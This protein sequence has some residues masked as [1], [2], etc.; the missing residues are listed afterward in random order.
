MT[1]K[2]ENAIVYISMLVNTVWGLL[3]YCLYL[4]YCIYIFPIIT[5][6]GVVWWTSK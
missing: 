2:A 6:T 1:V 4:L 5:Y 3:Y